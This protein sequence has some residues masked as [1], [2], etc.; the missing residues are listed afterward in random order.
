MLFVKSDNMLVFADAVI[1]LKEIYKQNVLK[2]AD[3]LMKTFLK[4]FF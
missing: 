3:F 4:H 2:I 1:Y